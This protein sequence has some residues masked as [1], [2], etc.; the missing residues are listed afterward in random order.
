MEKKN[1]HF[2]FKILHSILFKPQAAFSHNA[3]KAEPD[4]RLLPH[5]S[6]LTLKMSIAALCEWV[7][8]LLGCFFISFTTLLLW[9]SMLLNFGILTEEALSKQIF[10]DVWHVRIYYQTKLWSNLNFSTSRHKS[11]LKKI[12]H[13]KDVNNIYVS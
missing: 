8:L 12:K 4:S 3:A 13:I 5:V 10:K 7:P 9:R 6:Y 2:Y 11:T 1:F